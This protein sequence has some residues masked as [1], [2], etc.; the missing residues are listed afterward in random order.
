MVHS[1]GSH[2]IFSLKQLLQSFINK[3]NSTHQKP[4][5]ALPSNIKIPYSI[6]VFCSHSSFCLVECVQVS[7]HQPPVFPCCWKLC[8]SE[9][10]WDL[11]VESMTTGDWSPSNAVADHINIL[12]TFCIHWYGSS[13]PLNHGSMNESLEPSF[14]NERVANEWTVPWRGKHFPVDLIVNDPMSG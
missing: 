3:S 10:D 4:V 2:D 1:K 6:L 14:T 9:R 11:L 5:L 8:H 7:V 12:H 13:C